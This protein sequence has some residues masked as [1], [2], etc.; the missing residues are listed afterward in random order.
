MEAMRP[1]KPEKRSHPPQH[2]SLSLL[3]T[4]LTPIPGAP[5]Q[6]LQAEPSGADTHSQQDRQPMSSDASVEIMG[7]LRPETEHQ[8]AKEIRPGQ[9]VEQEIAIQILLTNPQI[10]QKTGP[11]PAPRTLMGE[12]DNAPHQVLRNNDQ[13]CEQVVTKGDR[14]PKSPEEIFSAQLAA[15][16]ELEEIALLYGLDVSA[17]T[18]IS[19]K[20]QSQQ[21]Q[22]AAKT[23]LA[24]LQSIQTY[25]TDRRAKIRRSGNN[26]LV[27]LGRI[28]GR[29]LAIERTRLQTL[30][31]QGKRNAYNYTDPRR[32]EVYRCPLPGCAGA[33]VNLRCI[34]TAINS[35]C[36]V[37]R[38]TRA[39]SFTFKVEFAKTW[40]ICHYPLKPK[41]SN[42]THALASFQAQEHERTNQPGLDQALFQRSQDERPGRLPRGLSEME[43]ESRADPCVSSLCMSLLSGLKP[44]SSPDNM[45]LC[46]D[47]ED[48]DRDAGVTG[49]GVHAVLHKQKERDSSIRDI[50]KYSKK[51]GAWEEETGLNPTGKKHMNLH[52]RESDK[53]QHTHSIN[54]THHET[55]APE[56]HAKERADPMENDAVQMEP[57]N[58]HA[59]ILSL[60]LPL[61]PPQRHTNSPRELPLENTG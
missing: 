6:T 60:P 56:L 38:E 27:T 33:L 22:Q 47:N 9:A 5:Q 55:K 17:L 37:Y 20:S 14:Y 2:R 10:T 8:P 3:V 54:R 24:T 51:H 31:Q 7:T 11:D 21:E 12:P 48:E 50:G 13:T 61:S 29:L 43:G 58:F 28:T 18:L 4:T 34:R 35:H 45:L 19:Q 32:G 57:R 16:V 42:P 36:N 26:F 1:S 23:E 15:P 40:D 53:A 46:A 30:E 52:I 59:A 39:I 25:L 49:T 44:A 41:G